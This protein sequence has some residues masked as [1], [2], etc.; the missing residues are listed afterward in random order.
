MR[1]TNQMYNFAEFSLGEILPL[2][3]KE[4][5]P[6][7]VH[8]QTPMGLVS[9][10]MSSPR[11][12]CFKRSQTCVGCGIEGNI[13]LMEGHLQV[14]PKGY[15]HCFRENCDWCSLQQWMRNEQHGTSPHLNMYHRRGSVLI[16]MTQDHIIPKSKGGSKH[17]QSNLQTMCT[18][19]NNKKGDMLPHEWLFHVYKNSPSMDVGSIRERRLQTLELYADHLANSQSRAA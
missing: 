7:Q 17:S 15:H 13:F 10:R 5:L 16:L 8:T 11:L 2:I 12:R 4:A 3:S 6:M 9:V 1:D 14:P 19:C 18:N